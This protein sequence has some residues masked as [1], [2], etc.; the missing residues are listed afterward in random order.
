[1]AKKLSES[2]QPARLKSIKSEDIK[3]RKWT[4]AERRTLRRIAERQAL[5]KR[6]RVSLDMPLLTDE[7]LAG[8]VRLRDARKA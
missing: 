7:Q 2:S 4:D 5:G 6:S 1:M 3:Y 8:M